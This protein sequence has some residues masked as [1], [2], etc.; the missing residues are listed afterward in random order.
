[1]A[2]KRSV[3]VSILITLCYPNDTRING[4]VIPGTQTGTETGHILKMRCM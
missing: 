4:L 3:N 1:M 2:V